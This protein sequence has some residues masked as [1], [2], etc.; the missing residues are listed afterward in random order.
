MLDHVKPQSRY[1]IPLVAIVLGAFGF[2]TADAQPATSSECNMGECAD[3]N[4][5]CTAAA[6]HCEVTLE[7]DGWR[8][9]DNVC[10]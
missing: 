9:D 3:N 8:C 2:I 5:W 4:Q 1:V 10:W 7:P 6:M